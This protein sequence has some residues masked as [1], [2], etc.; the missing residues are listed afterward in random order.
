MSEGLGKGKHAQHSRNYFLSDIPLKRAQEIQVTMLKDI[1]FVDR[2]RTEMV[3]L[4]L[5]SGRIVSR[6]IEARFSSPI[7]NTA[8]MDG[9]AITSSISVGASESIPITLH[10]IGQYEWVDTGDALPDW[11]DS[12]VMIEDIEEV[13]G[14]EILLRSPVGPYQHVRREAEDF[15]APELLLHAGSKITAR[16]LAC[17]GASGIGQVPV[18][19][20]PRVSIIPTGNELVPSGQKPQ[21]GQVIE[22]NSAV[23]SA[24]CKDWGAE[25]EVLPPVSDVLSDITNAIISQSD[26]SDI[27]LILAGSSAG[28]EDFTSAAVQAVGSVAF[29]GVAIRPGHPI[30]LGNV[31]S[32]AI[33]GI[34]GYPA[35]AEL[36]ADLFLKPMLQLFDGRVIEMRESVTAEL[37]RRLS[38]SMGDDEFIKVILGHIGERYV[39]TPLSRGAAMTL[40]M[41]KADGLLKIPADR[42]GFEKGEKVSIELITGRTV[43]DKTVL[44][45]GSDDIAIRLLEGEVQNQFP[46]IRLRNSSVG[47]VGGLVA[48]G[49]RSAQIAGSHLLDPETGT[50]NIAA[51]KR[52]LAGRNFKLVDFVGRT[53]GLIFRRE[54]ISDI[55]SIESISENNLNFI[56]RQRGSGTRLFFDHLLGVHDIDPS[57][58]VGYEVEEY[59]H[60]AI[61]AAVLSGSADVGVGIYAAAEAND[62]QFIPLGQERFQFV[63]PSEESED[64]RVKA[65]LSVLKSNRLKE[66]IKKLGGYD[67]S[68]MGDVSYE[69]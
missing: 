65:V 36:T 50:Y 28:S 42:E 67:V 6:N 43:I 53:Q 24:L 68:L 10:S 59:T 7:Y 58:I 21:P 64:T 41:S 20:M 48:L 11:A 45:S 49:D 22:F 56:N 63:I 35:S 46:E 37:T 34:P 52:L 60:W 39:A 16:D 15:A 47:S 40:S 4:D 69:T 54:S 9:I 29:H 25:V 1:G 30:L 32:V 57:E 2:R 66:A 5:A 23:I 27:V 18:T 13:E 33:M 26:V 17:L 31:G 38:S 3:P 19:T 55:E 14:G 51:S 62:L 61:A 44:M 12:V 8:A